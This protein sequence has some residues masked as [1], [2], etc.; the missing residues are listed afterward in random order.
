MHVKEGWV[1][2]LSEEHCRR[3][4]AALTDFLSALLRVEG[5]QLSVIAQQF[6]CAFLTR[7]DAKFNASEAVCTLLK[8]AKPMPR[9]LFD[10]LLEQ[11]RTSDEERRLVSFSFSFF[12]LDAFFVTT[13]YKL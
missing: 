10:A 4:E 13:T 9:R 1:A 2:S 8:T 7:S 12:N 5:L 6:L 3:F 11:I